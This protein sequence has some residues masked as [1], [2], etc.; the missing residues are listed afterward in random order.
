MTGDLN[1]PSD[2]GAYTIDTMLRDRGQIARTLRD[3][4]DAQIIA[5]TWLV[6]DFDPR[7]LHRRDGWA[8]RRY[9][10]NH[11]RRVGAYSP[12]EVRAMLAADEPARTRAHR[13]SLRRPPS[14][15]TPVLIGTRPT[16]LKFY[17][18]RD[19]N[20]WLTMEASEPLLE[21]PILQGPPGAPIEDIAE[22]DTGPLLWQPAAAMLGDMFEE[23]PS[24]HPADD[25]VIPFC[26]GLTYGA[27]RARGLLPSR[28]TPGHRRDT[29]T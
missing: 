18:V 13:R 29:A 9:R 24:L 5:R 16:A 11:R 1:W 15:G 23:W 2:P 20:G 4:T 26:G 8:L 25:E 14:D 27:A 7:T 21:L 19:V 22:A 6:G 17:D 12:G 28:E 10:G 3:M